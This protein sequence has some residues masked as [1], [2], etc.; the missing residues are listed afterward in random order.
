MAVKV[1]AGVLR[2]GHSAWT[3]GV[4]SGR[5]HGQMAYY[6]NAFFDAY[7]KNGSVSKLEV[8]KSRVSTLDFYH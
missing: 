7:L 2:A 4:L 5:F 3:D 8:K 1:H 6:L